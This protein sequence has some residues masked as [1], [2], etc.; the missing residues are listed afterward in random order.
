MG[1]GVS[2]PSLMKHKLLSVIS[3]CA[4][5]DTERNVVLNVHTGYVWSVRNG[6]DGANRVTINSSSQA[7]P[8]EQLMSMW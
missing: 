4:L 6:E 2:L 3:S 5:G 1:P 7:P 8:P